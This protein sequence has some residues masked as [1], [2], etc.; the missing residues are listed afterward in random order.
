[1]QDFEKP[2][3]K[4]FI[5]GLIFL[6]A[7]LVAGVY[8]IILGGKMVIGI[9]NYAEGKRATEECYKLQDQSRVFKGPFYLTQGEKD[10]CDYYG[11]K[12]DAPV[13]SRYELE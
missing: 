12:I 2:S 9:F 4:G 1:M 3:A 5:L 11:I 8:A 10:Q 7:C 6:I 13:K